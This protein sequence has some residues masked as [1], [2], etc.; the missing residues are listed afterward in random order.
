MKHRRTRKTKTNAE[1]AGASEP[2]TRRDMIGEV[3]L[4]GLTL[5]GVALT[6]SLIPVSEIKAAPQAVAA[7]KTA[8]AFL[9][10][11]RRILEAFI[12]RIIPRDENGPGALDAGAADYIDRAFVEF[13]GAEKESFAQGIAAVDA[14]ARASQGGPFAELSPEKRDAVFMAIDAG[15]A[16]QLR[17]FFNRARRLTLE[18]MFC[19][20]HW[21]GNKNFA[22]WDL[23][24][25]PGVRLLV[26]PDDQK[27]SVPVKPVH[28]SAYD[29]GD[30]NHGH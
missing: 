28:R 4:G 27:M 25:Y 5:A 11:Q 17:A 1:L 20:P 19:D 14:F 21:G 24:Q 3:T 6:S 13:L 26:T 12:D 30:Q 18:G 15:Q 10:E 23:I 9:P 16:N 7:A 8:S 29:T 22:G 2:I